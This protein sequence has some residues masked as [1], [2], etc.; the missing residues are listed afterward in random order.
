VDHPVRIHLGSCFGWARSLMG[1]KRLAIS[2]YREP[3]LVHEIMDFCVPA[4][5][6]F[7]HFEYYVSLVKQYIAQ[8]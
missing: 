8:V 7:E 6:P 1:L 3:D 5:V 2:F 4:D